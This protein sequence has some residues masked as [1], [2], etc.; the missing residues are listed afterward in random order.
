V[1]TCKKR[2]SGHSQRARR[3]G[4]AQGTEEPH[5]GPAEVPIRLDAGRHTDV[6]GLQMAC[7]R[8]V[9]A[10]VTQSGSCAS[11][12]GGSGT[13]GRAARM[14]HGDIQQDGTMGW[15][16]RHLNVGPR[17]L[18]VNCCKANG[19]VTGLRTPVTARA[20]GDAAESYLPVA[21]TTRA[22]SAQA[23]ATHGVV[24]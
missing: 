12:R 15:G 9:L 6:T 5:D 21:V 8:P 20:G 1:S 11:R 10:H 3:R 4:I 14:R 23:I 19:S 7:M 2:A 24:D 13:V 18:T 16:K 17:P 22:A